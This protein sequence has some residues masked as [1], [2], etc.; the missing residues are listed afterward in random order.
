MIFCVSYCLCYNYFNDTYFPKIQKEM[1]S[2]Q[3]RVLS[4]TVSFF[5]YCL[6]CVF[7]FPATIKLCYLGNYGEALDSSDMVLY[8]DTG[9]SL[10]F[11]L[12]TDV[13]IKNTR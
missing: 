5:C 2:K 10:F 6:G 3:L 11:S 4:A 7:Q 13:Q 8:L 9:F 1:I 12:L